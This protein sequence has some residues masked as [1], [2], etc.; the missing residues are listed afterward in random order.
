MGR[1][2]CLL[3]YVLL[4]AF[5]SNW[6]NYSCFFPL[7][8]DLNPDSSPHGKAGFDPAPPRCKYLYE[9]IQD[10]IRDMFMESALVTVGLE[11][12]LER[13]GFDDP[14]PGEVRDLKGGKSG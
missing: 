13:L 8:F 1:F 9:V 7:C 14:F 10:G 3:T 11:V 12:K 5:I 2:I 6:E 4:P